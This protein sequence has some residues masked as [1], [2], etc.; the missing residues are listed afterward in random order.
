MNNNYDSY[1]LL[2]TIKD[3][4]NNIYNSIEIDYNNILILNNFNIL[5]IN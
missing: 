4:Y 2:Y 5:K 3:D 1:D